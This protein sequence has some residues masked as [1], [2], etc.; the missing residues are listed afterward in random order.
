[1]VAD[2]ALFIFISEELEGKGW[3]RMAEVLWEF[4]KK[5]GNMSCNRGG[6]FL[7]PLVAVNQLQNKLYKEALVQITM[8]VQSHE[9]GVEK[10]VLW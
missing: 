4:A 6:V 5:G 9:R 8:P 10:S 3:R 7:R 2:V 1:M